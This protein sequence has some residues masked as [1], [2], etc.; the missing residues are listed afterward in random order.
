MGRVVLM[1]LAVRPGV[2]LDVGLVMTR[3]E[4]CRMWVLEVTTDKRRL[5]RMLDK[6]PEISRWFQCQQT[7]GPICAFA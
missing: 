4:S 7:S 3:Q 5:T 2:V 1:T 6:V